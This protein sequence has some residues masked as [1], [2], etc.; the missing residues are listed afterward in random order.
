MV[1]FENVINASHVGQFCT[2]FT[3]VKK[4][5]LQEFYQKQFE[6][7]SGPQWGLIWVLTVCKNT[8]QGKKSQLV[9]EELINPCPSECDISFLNSVDVASGSKSTVFSL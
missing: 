7:R 8:P 6:S 5:N 3:S 4:K 2:V 1:I 9:A